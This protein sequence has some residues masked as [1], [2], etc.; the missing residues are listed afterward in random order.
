[1]TPSGA[2][3]VLH[4]FPGVDGLSRATGRGDGRELLRV[5]LLRRDPRPGTVFQMTPGGT[6]TVLTSS[7][8]ER[9]RRPSGALI[10]AT[11]RKLY[12]TTING[13]SENAGTVFQITRGMS[14]VSARVHRL[15]AGRRSRSRP[16]RRATDG[17]FYGTTPQNGGNSPPVFKMTPYGTFMRFS[18]YWFTGATRQ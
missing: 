5:H 11:D 8:W 16:D 3:S 4:P 9:R 7:P 18:L 12:G 1:M 13:G 14:P 17:N 10:Q 6:F 2:V 15:R